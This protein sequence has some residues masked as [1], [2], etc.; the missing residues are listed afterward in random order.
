M[1]KILLSL[2][3]FAG[4]TATFAQSNLKSQNDNTPIQIIGEDVLTNQTENFG[5]RG[6][7]T[8]ADTNRWAWGRSF[9]AGAATYYRAFMH[10]DTLVPNAYG[11]Y[12]N[13]PSGMIVDVSG[14]R[15]YGWSLR[16]DGASVSVNA[17]LYAAG[18][19]SLPMGAALA[20]VTITLDTTTGGIAPTQAIFSSAVNLTGSFI[21]SIE[22]STVQ[23]DSIGVLR[24]YTGSGTAD[25]FPAVYK[26]IDLA[27][28]N[29][30]RL[31]GTSFG[32]R[33][34]HYY[35]YVSY[36]VTNDFT[37]S[38]TK[39]SGANESVDFVYDG[40]VITD[41]PIWSFTGHLGDTTSTWMFGD[42]SSM[43]ARSTSH[44]FVV[45]T[46]DY[47]ITL[48]DSVR[49]WTG[50]YCLLTET[51]TLLKAYPLGIE[52]ASVISFTAFISNNEIH[53]SNAN[54]LA[55]LYSITGSVVQQFNITNNSEIVN[56]SE[57]NDGVYILSVN[58]EAIRLKK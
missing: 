53:I 10:Y 58:G 1:K 23:G 18:T 29:Y 15:L 3:L 50:N 46:Q 36:S 30:T 26:A 27:G 8:C 55:T 34:A 43:K 35:P 52:D 45:P 25:N 56:I 48:V 6:T 31:P 28:G 5:T 54:G 37:M 16:P 2:A 47:D 57:L 12:V 19:D 22:N 4:A 44:E 42:G 38:V 14:F 21:I 51:K 7:N 13:V 20:T 32:A 17:V 49:L 40:P 11:T 33:L 24:G 9:D 39:L 41:N